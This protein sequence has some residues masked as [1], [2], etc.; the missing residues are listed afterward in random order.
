MLDLISLRIIILD[1]IQLSKPFAVFA[2]ISNSNLHMSLKQK[3]LLNRI[4]LLMCCFYLISWLVLPNNGVDI[5]F[6]HPSTYGKLQI[7]S[8]LIYYFTTI[9]KGKRHTITFVCIVLSSVLCGEYRA[10]GEAVVAIM[11]L[12]FIN[13]Q[14]KFNI[15][16]IA[17]GSLILIVG[18][19]SVWSKFDRY[20]V[21]GISEESSAR[22]ILYVTSVKIAKDYFPLGSGFG[23]FANDASRVEYSPVY[24]MYGISNVY[25]LSRIK[26]NFIADTFFPCVIGEFG[27]VG[28]FLFLYLF[29]YIYRRLNSIYSSK[30]ARIRYVVGIAII[31]IL[32]IESVAGPSLVTS[33]GVPYM[34]LTGYVINDS[35][36]MNRRINNLKRLHRKIQYM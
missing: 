14:I 3:Q 33:I 21:R 7:L 23:S 4:S 10:I 5:I 34:L 36:V 35:N 25:G 18:L 9:K 1:M 8:S 2:C 27:F 22:G 29:F 12:L 19:A 26:N 17:I 16:N 31:A 32:I 30:N 15:R 20:F 11:L 6:T 24:D 28:L 13:E